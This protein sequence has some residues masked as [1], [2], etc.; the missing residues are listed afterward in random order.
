MCWWWMPTS[1][2]GN[3]RGTVAQGSNVYICAFCGPKKP[4][5]SFVDHV[6]LLR[7]NISLLSI[8][9]IIHW[10][11]DCDQISSPVSEIHSF[12]CLL[13][14]IESEEY[15]KSISFCLAMLFT[16]DSCTCR[17]SLGSRYRDCLSTCLLWLLL[18]LPVTHIFQALPLPSKLDTYFSSFAS[19]QTIFDCFPLL[20]GMVTCKFFFVSIWWSCWPFF[21]VFAEYMPG[22]SLY[23]YLHKNKRA[24]KFSELLKF[25]IDVSKGMEYLHHNDIIHRDLKSAN[26]LMDSLQV[27]SRNFIAAVV[28]SVQCC[29]QCHTMCWSWLLNLIFGEIGGVHFE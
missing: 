2:F 4:A 6:D 5:T 29:S 8:L 24:L 20:A 19:Q 15:K 17:L 27:R 21:N 10:C 13:K 22:G 11:G 14:Y 1:S 7:L 18:A 25:A 3:I 23:N 26:L 9:H 28:F 12:H 16:S